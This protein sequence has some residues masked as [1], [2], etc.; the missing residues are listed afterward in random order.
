MINACI[1]NN[2]SKTEKD[3]SKSTHPVLVDVGRCTS[4]IGV[5]VGVGVG[6]AAVPE[7]GGVGEEAPPRAPSSRA[8]SSAF[9][10]LNRQQTNRNRPNHTHARAKCIVFEIGVGNS[11]REKLLRKKFSCPELEIRCVSKCFL[12]V[13]CDEYWK[14]RLKYIDTHRSRWKMLRKW[15][16]NR[17]NANLFQFECNL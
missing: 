16:I 4:S 13:S 5:Q 1:E 11:G 7:G 17:F 2:H 8:R 15:L 14:T 12:F 9:C 3:I 10:P 6:V